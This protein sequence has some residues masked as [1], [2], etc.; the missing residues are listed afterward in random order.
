[1]KIER[2]DT[3]DV[4][5]IGGGPAGLSAALWCDELGL[6]A[7]LIE[8][9][10]DLGGQLRQ[11][12]NSIEN[13]LGVTAANGLEM[14]SRF[15]LSL[16]SRNF[17][18][19][20]GIKA[21]AIDTKAMA[22]HLDG[23]AGEKI[24]CSAI[25]LATGVRRRSLDIPGEI[26]FRGKGILESGS[27]DKGLVSGKRVLIVGGGDAAFE[28]AMILSQGAASVSVAYR[29]SE[30]SA[31]NEFV[32]AA[33][34]QENVELLPGTVVTRIAGN[35]FVE[36]VD[37]QDA[38]GR[39]RTELFDAVLIRIGVEPNSELARDVLEL[40]EAGYVRV[41][42]NGETSAANVYA[43]G[44]VANRCSPTLSTAAGTAA[45]SAKAIFLSIKTRKGYNV[46]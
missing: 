30:P 29:R 1:M 2:D 43:V 25:I 23:S 31:R 32:D 18:P 44:D 41:D 4:I 28:N 34:R 39:P 40:D 5:I 13:Y 36:K 46:A 27:R 15:E 22:V 21:T 16:R 11:I 42:Q 7:V 14:S 3:A 12:Y 24:S 19:R 33:R 26:E 8:K 45:T 37:V 20:I 6:D 17:V 35:M 9:A 10:D 38:A